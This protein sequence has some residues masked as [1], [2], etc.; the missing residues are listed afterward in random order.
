MR[1]LWYKRA[2]G[3]TSRTDRAV[4][5]LRFGSWSDVAAQ[6][7][8]DRQDDEDDEQNPR[9]VGRD[10]RNPAKA[11]SGR[12]ESDDQEYDS[13]LKHWNSPLVAQQICRDI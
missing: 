3:A 10:A 9:D 6:E 7:C 13:P 8:D 4:R 11:E 12:D 1:S 2:N 5:F